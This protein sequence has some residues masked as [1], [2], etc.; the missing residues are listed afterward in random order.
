MWSLINKYTRKI[1]YDITCV[2][3]KTISTTENNKSYN[4]RD[5]YNYTSDTKIIIISTALKVKDLQINNKRNRLNF[6]LILRKFPSYNYSV[7]DCISSRLP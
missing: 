1:I 4:T 2:T 6:Y 5:D 7:P 3:I